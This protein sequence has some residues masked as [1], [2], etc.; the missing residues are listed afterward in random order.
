MDLKEKFT[1]YVRDHQVFSIGDQLIIAVSG[2]VDSVMLCELCRQTGYHFSVAHCNFTLRGEESERDEL[3]VRELA[4]KYHVPF[5]VKRFDTN[6]YAA[7][8][9]VSI[10]VAAREL[11]YQWFTELV[12][13]APGSLLLTAHHADDN[14]ET[15]VMNFFRGTGLRGLTGI[16]LKNEFIRRPLLGISRKELLAFAGEYNLPWVE[17]SSNLSVDYTRNFFR[18]EILPAISSVYPAVEDNLQDNISR[19]RATGKLYKIAVDQ[20]KKKLCKQK[21]AEL[22]IPVKQWMAY[23]SKALIFEIIRDYGFGEKQLDEVIKLANSESGR[24][25]ESPDQRYRLIRHRHWFIM[26][27]VTAP[28]ANHI[29]IQGGDTNIQ[30]AG[31][32]ISMSKSTGPEIKPSKDKVQAWL[33]ASLL[34]FPLLLRRWKTGDYFY[35]LGM[36]KKKKLSRFFIDQKMSKADKENAWVLESGKKICWV[37]GQRIDDR[38]KIKTDSKSATVLHLTSKQ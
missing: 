5:F 34:E 19:F 28:Q 32:R 33:D 16:P 30:F 1:N 18:K 11:R 2:G 27:P 10:Q 12:Q 24:F 23:E 3:F 35:P 9:K 20:L 7:E 36:P 15:I 25:I 31:G 38:F 21:G 29:I 14:A 22:H 4:G 13:E 6:R 17:D 26:A 8:R 37:V